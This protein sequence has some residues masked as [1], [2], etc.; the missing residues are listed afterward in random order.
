MDWD[1]WPKVLVSALAVVAG[2]LKLWEIYRARTA[3]LTELKT[4]LEV[5]DLLPDES[6]AKSIATAHVERRLAG[7]VKDEQEKRRNAAGMTLALLFIVF[8][9]TAAYGAIFESR[10]WWIPA[11]PFLIFGF[12]GFSQ[13]GV[14]RERDAK[15]RA[16]RDKGNVVSG[17]R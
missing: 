4:L 14:K 2:A 6:A 10:W 13:D 3:R 9:G 5:A 16:I 12:V 7:F 1:T 15:G 11:V 8:S 17:G